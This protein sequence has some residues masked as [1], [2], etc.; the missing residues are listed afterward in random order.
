MSLPP[1][2]EIPVLME[3]FAKWL[4]EK[5]ATAQIAIEAHFK[6]VAI[7]PFDDGNGRTARLLMNLILLRSGYPPLVISPDVRPDYIDVLERR[8]LTGEVR[9]YELFMTGQL[10]RSLDHYLENT[11][12]EIAINGGD[13]AD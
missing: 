10:R 7:H 12:K 4:A 9:P 6:L 8:H 13:N 2:L 3:A 11:A 5:T 1:P